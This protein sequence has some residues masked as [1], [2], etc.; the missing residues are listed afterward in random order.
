MITLNM[1]DKTIYL[2]N[3]TVN[4]ISREDY[5]SLEKSLLLA[6]N[7]NIMFDGR[8]ILSFNT[9]DGLLVL[10]DTI[11]TY[12]ILDKKGDL[13]G[14]VFSSK[15]ST[16][17]MA[18]LTNTDKKDFYSVLTMISSNVTDMS[19]KLHILIIDDYDTYADEVEKLKDR[20]EKDLYYLV[21]K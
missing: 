14:Q 21:V 15:N 9:S 10:D 8:S 6:D 2:S 16:V 11:L 5:T 18:K 1:S 7:L 19:D 13:G 12:S 3:N 4:T 20:L 17:N